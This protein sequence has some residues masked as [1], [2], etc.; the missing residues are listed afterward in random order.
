MYLL[1]MVEITSGNSFEPKQ[2]DRT[3]TGICSR[4]LESENVLEKTLTLK[5]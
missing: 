4:V 3:E 5:S 1:R 2:S